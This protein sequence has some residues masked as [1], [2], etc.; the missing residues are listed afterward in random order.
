MTVP[1]FINVAKVGEI[2]SG[3]GRLVMGPFDKPMA[4]FNLDGE[5]YAINFVCPHMGGP[6]GSGSLQ[7]SVVTRPWHG[8]TFDIRDGRPIM[9]AG[10]AS[11]PTRPRSRATIFWWGGSNPGAKADG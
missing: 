11:R 3:E 9:R 8:W 10:I 2:P 7:G 5:Y 6:L 1:S 4:L